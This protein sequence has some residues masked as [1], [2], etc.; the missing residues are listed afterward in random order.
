[1]LLQNQYK[2]TEESRLRQCHASNDALALK[3]SMNAEEEDA[4]SRIS[5]LQSDQ[6][7]TSPDEERRH[8]RRNDA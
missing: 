2:L 5:A 7:V 4:Y 8:A 1:M 3:S 6:T